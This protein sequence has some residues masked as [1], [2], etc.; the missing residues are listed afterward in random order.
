VADP[1]SVVTDTHPLIFHAA[2]GRRLGRR[3]AR[4]FAA[5]ERGDALMFVPAVV[6]WEC[7]L[8]SR[9]GRVDFRRPIAAFF[10]D[11]F[12]NA[13]FQP[14]ALDADQIYLADELRFN[15]DPFDALVCAAARSVEL[16]LISNDGDIDASGIVDIVW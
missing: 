11:L 4:C 8:L 5:C 10:V 6:I 16:P 15:E 1:V 7:A 12:S 13:A 3:A 14:L 2:G 9:R